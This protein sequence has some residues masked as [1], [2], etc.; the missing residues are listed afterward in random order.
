[1]EQDDFILLSALQHY[2]YCPRQCALIHEEQSFADNLHTARGNAVHTL[3]DLAGYELRAGVRIERALPLVCERL[4]LIGKADIVEILPDGTPYPVEYKHGPRRQRTHDDVQLAA[5]A[6]CLEEM[7]GHPVPLGAIY[8]A[9]SH[10]RR[11]VAI[12]LDLRQLVADTTVAI[13]TMLQS[14]QMP[15]AVN[16]ARCRECSL[17]DLCQP[18]MLA[19]KARRM[20]LRT[21]LFSVED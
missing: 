20:K 5:Q 9:S 7:T 21:H 15:P 13:R 6:L 14:G 17:I 19:E 3:V 8:H 2:S 12:T 1:M 10:R 18:Q 11:E 4:G 16:D